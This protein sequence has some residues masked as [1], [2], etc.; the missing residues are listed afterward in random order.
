MSQSSY[1]QSKQLANVSLRSFTRLTKRNLIKPEYEDRKINNE[2][3]KKVKQESVP[4]V[5]IE[6]PTESEIECR[7]QP[8][9]WQN[10]LKGI[11]EMRSKYDAPVDTMGCERCHDHDALPS[12]QRFQILASLMLSSQTRDEVTS[13]A[14][15]RLKKRGLTVTSLLDISDEELGELI[16][17]VGFWRKKVGYLKRTAAAILEQGGD[18]PNTVEGLCKLPGVGPKMAYLAMQCAWGIQ[19]GIGVDT[20]VHRISNRLEW[21]KEPSKNPEET[22]KKLEEWLPKPL[23]GEINAL[24]V[25]FGQQ[26]CLPISPRCHECLIQQQCPFGKNNIKMKS[27][28]KSPSKMRTSAVKTEIKTEI[29]TDLPKVE[30]S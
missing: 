3:G 16:K 15:E 6:P 12:V 20:H 8:E 17:P 27:P 29:E 4:A 21:M 25:G 18:I 7:W 24:L 11:R 19:D 13:A 28:K 10:Q 1:F 26:I 23:W 14:M 5:K 22:R 2:N 9:L 30:Q